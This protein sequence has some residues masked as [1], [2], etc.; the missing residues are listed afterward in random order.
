MALNLEAVGQKIGPV[1]KDYSWKDVILY[2]L[3]VG[4]GFDEIEYVYEKDLKVIPS[5]GIA[6][7]VS[8]MRL[9]VGRAFGCVPSR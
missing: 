4:A 5:F 8:V 7:R 3:G 2:A 1:K 9:S 6:A